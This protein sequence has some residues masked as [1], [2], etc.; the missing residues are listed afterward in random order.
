MSLLD[1]LWD[2][3]V[4]G[5]RPDSGL[6]KLRKYSSFSPSSSAS[7]SAATAPGSFHVTRSITILRTATSPCSTLDSASSAPSS[8]ASVPDSPITPT[9]LRG[10][11][12]RPRRKPAPMA[13]GM[14]TA[15]PRN[16]TVYDWVVISSLDR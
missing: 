16:P 7:A 9:G 8:P 12:R 10:E 6:G 1:H 11:W 3:T 14:E 15:E 13:E 2:E 4:A 5:P